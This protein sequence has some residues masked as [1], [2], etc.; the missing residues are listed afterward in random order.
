MNFFNYRSVFSGQI[1]DIEQIS[2]A[3]T[4]VLLLR[5]EPLP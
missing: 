2:D 1:I 4:L 3:E 5:R